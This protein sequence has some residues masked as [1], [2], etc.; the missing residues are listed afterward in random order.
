MTGN[1]SRMNPAC[2]SQIHERRCQLTFKAVFIDD[3]SSEWFSTRISSENEKIDF[4]LCLSQ[5]NLPIN[6]PM[7]INRRNRRFS[8]NSKSQP[9]KHEIPRASFSYVVASRRSSIPRGI[10]IHTALQMEPYEE[11]FSQTEPDHRQR[12]YRFCIS[13]LSMR[14]TIR[15]HPIAM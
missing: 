3:A 4:E 11:Q 7:S 14:G 8:L 9:S 1:R 5:F 13:L 6:F 15:K 10:W 12:T 2:Q